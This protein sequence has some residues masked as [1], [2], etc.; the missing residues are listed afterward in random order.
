MPAF[1]LNLTK[2]VLQGK[3][4]CVR[5]ST[6]EKQMNWPVIDVNSN[7]MACSKLS[8]LTMAFLRQVLAKVFYQQMSVAKKALPAHAPSTM[9]PD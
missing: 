9:V 6:V 3:G 5:S 7:A 1:C 2:R 8:S 4:T